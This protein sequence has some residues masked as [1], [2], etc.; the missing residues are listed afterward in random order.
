MYLSASIAQFYDPGERGRRG[1][2]NGSAAPMDFELTRRQREVY[3]TVGELARDRFAARVDALDRDAA[4]PIENMRDPT[5][6][7]CS[8]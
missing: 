5:G 2:A 6:P 1:G 4:T 3:E 8:T 7:A